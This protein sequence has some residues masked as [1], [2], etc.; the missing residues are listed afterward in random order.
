MFS[1]V[2]CLT[3]LLAFLPGM[4][5]AEVIA[6][7]VT[8][9]D[10]AV[11][12][13]KV[14]VSANS[15]VALSVC[16]KNGQPIATW[17]ADLELPEGL[18]IAKNAYGD[19]MIV[20]SGTRTTPSRHSIATNT[21]ENGMVRILYN[22][23][24]NNTILDTDGEVATLTLNVAAD[25]EPGEYP[26]VFRN[27]VLS[28]T[29]QTGHKLDQVACLLT[30]KGDNPSYEEGYS[31]EI[32]PFTLAKGTSYDIEAEES[33]LF[34]TVLLVNA[35]ETTTLDFD[36]A[37]PEGLGIGTYQYNRG[38]PKKPDWVDVYDSYYAGNYESDEY[39][40]EAEKNE[41]GTIHV[42]SSDMTFVSSSTPVAV[43]Q[44]P[45][46]ADEAVADGV[47]ELTLKNIVIT[48]ADGTEYH[49]ANYTTSIFVGD[50]SSISEVPALYGDFA[51]EGV[52][53]FNAAFAENKVATSYDFT[54]ATGFDAE[55][56]FAPGNKNALFIA[57]EGVVPANANN[58]IV[59]DVCAN[60]VLTDGFA[61]GPA[62][63][64]TVK[65]GEYSRT[66]SADTYGTIVLPFT[67]D[68]ET[69][70]DYTFYELTDVE[71]NALTFDEVSSPVAGKP[72]IVTSD[73]T[74]TKMSAEAESTVV[75][76]PAATEADGW[77]MTGTYESVVFTDADELA[78][79]YCISGN[80]FKQ[81]TSKLTMNP[82]RAY[83][84]GDGSAKS[85]ELRGD[86][87]TT[88]IIDLT[89]DAKKGVLY[90]VLG[91]KVEMPAQGIYIHNGKKTL[92][93]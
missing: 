72:Y 51:A 47:Y 53:A 12:V 18:A 30:V 67:P 35:I 4:L 71:T 65:A 43:I 44:L 89:E 8:T 7:D 13:P 20:V 32:A 41:D 37:L 16:L 69:L 57:S 62:K 78:N 5:H 40:P 73:G 59:N 1:F 90:D 91:R 6:T 81:A 23:A 56:V 19:L 74:A 39:F 15:E 29:N 54:N 60:L 33:N 76:E 66:L 70:K 21:L 88:R 50:L 38:T 42:S 82:F 49:A 26:I 25:V 83:F 55:T 86:D 2:S 75:V 3:A 27:I 87:G 77:T 22:S 34:I 93:K 84:V 58:V 63:T 79:L 48:D 31:L 10:Y 68:A 46:T 61:F 52:K 9:L 85:I 36:L 17:Q 28:E 11:Y 45:V 14:S 64:F 92:V 80:Q 24:A